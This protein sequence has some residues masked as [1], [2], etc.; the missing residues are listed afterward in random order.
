MNKVYI[1]CLFYFL[2]SCNSTRDGINKKVLD[3]VCEIHV[4]NRTPDSFG[5]VKE[6]RIKDKKEIVSLCNELLSL[7]QE[8]DL[9][10]RPY[11]G[12]IVIEFMRKDQYGVGEYINILSTGIILKPNSEYYI[13]YSRGQYVSDHFLARI[14]KYL[15][16]DESKVSALDA[17]R[18]SKNL[19]EDNVPN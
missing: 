2:I 4:Q 10:T 17:Y 16:I 11:D 7:K 19:K 6:Y 14:L 5:G 12:T 1:F 3:S 9:Q 13:T 18:K 15:E 8:N